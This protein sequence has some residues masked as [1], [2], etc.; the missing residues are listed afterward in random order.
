MNVLCNICPN[1][2]NCDI[3]QPESVSLICECGEPISQEDCYTNGGYCNP[4]Y[5]GMV[6]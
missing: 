1:V 3:E 6:L 5:L 2:E 4:C